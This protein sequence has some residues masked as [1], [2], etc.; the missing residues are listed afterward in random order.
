MARI[1]VAIVFAVSA[2]ALTRADA[3]APPAADYAVRAYGAQGDGKTND[4]P[5]VQRAIDACAAAG[6][7][8][9]YLAPG[10]YL[11]GSLHLRSGVV[12]WL[13]AGAT[14]KGSPRHADYD[15]YEKL[16]FPNASDHETS[17]FH[18]ALIWGEDVERVGIV[19]QGTI[20]ANRRKRGGPKPIALKRCRHVA[21][22]AS[23]SRTLPIT[24]SA[25]S[26]PT[27]S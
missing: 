9:V 18:F 1:W 27:T 17:Y 4:T 25:C 10:V 16:G 21:F 7:G 3:S 5:L 23:P 12:L 15:A 6:G 22:A 14:V 26:A 20:D 13:D 11:C 8:T 2:G 24:T 19:G